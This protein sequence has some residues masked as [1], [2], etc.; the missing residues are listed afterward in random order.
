MMRAARCALVLA[1]AVGPAA[2]AVFEERVF[3]T[4]AAERRYHALI[5]ELRCLVC[6]N[7]N[8]AESDAG[9][10]ADLRQQV[11]EMVRAG[12]GDEEIIEFMVARYGDFVRYR[13]PLR[14]ATVAL[15]VG[16]FVLSAFGVWAL[17]RQIARNRRAAGAAE[18][19]AS[20]RERL[21][22]LLDTSEGEG[23]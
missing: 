8:I 16:P 21:R 19:D 2:G 18:L 23:R 6:Q 13:P 7:Q 12:A 15:W 17:V 1:L 11:Y 3:D 9:L 14:P 10:A 20:E 22:A 5:D 4:P